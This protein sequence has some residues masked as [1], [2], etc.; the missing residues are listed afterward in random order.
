MRVIERVMEM[1]KEEEEER[2]GKKKIDVILW[3]SLQFMLWQTC[4]FDQEETHC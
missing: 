2:N 1:I 3:G 4:H